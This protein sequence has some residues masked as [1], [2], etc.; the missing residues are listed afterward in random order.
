MLNLLVMVAVVLPLLF[1]LPLLLPVGKTCGEN[2]KNKV[3]FR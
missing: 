3:S 1:V 2:G